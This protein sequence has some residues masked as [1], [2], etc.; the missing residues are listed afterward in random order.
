VATLTVYPGVKPN[1]TRIAVLA[2]DLVTPI[3][4]AGA[5]V[6]YSDYYIALLST[7]QLL[8]YDPVDS[9]GT[10][11]QLLVPPL[12]VTGTP[13]AGQVIEATGPSTAEWSDPETSSLDGPSIE[14]VIASPGSTAGQTK[15]CTKRWN[16]SAHP[17]VGCELIWSTTEATVDGCDV[18]ANFAGL[19]SWRRRHTG[20]HPFAGSTDVRARANGTTN[21]TAAF[22]NWIDRYCRLAEL[23]SGIPN[24][25]PCLRL[26]STDRVLVDDTLVYDPAEHCAD[27]SII[28]A[29]TRSTSDFGAMILWNRN[30]G[31][32]GYDTRPMFSIGQRGMRFQGVWLAPNSGRTLLSAIDWKLMPGGAATAM[33]IHDCNIK[34]FAGG[35]Y[36]TYG[37]TTDIHGSSDGNLEEADFRDVHFGAVEAGIYINKGQPLN[38]TLYKCSFESPSGSVVPNSRGIMV[39]IG[40]C[41][42]SLISPNFG[43]L[44]TGVAIGDNGGGLQL[45]ISGFFDAERTKRLIGRHDGSLDGN[46]GNGGGPITIGP[47]RIAARSYGVASVNPTI[48]AEEDTWIHAPFGNTT[49]TMI[50]TQFLSG[51]EALPRWKIYAP[52]S[53]VVA[54]GVTFPNT[55]PIVTRAAARPQ[56]ISLNN[57]LGRNAEVD[58]GPNVLYDRIHS[59]GGTR[60]P[61]VVSVVIP[62]PVTAVTVPFG[63]VENYPPIVFPPAVVAEAG[64]PSAG[65]LQAPTVSAITTRSCLVTLG[66]APG[67]SASVRVSLS[68]S[69][70]LATGGLLGE[71]AFTGGSTVRATAVS[72]GLR[73]F[74]WLAVWA[75]MNAVPSATEALTSCYNAPNGFI[76]YGSGNGTTGSVYCACYSVAGNTNSPTIAISAADVNRTH[77][78]FF[79]QDATTLRS[80]AKRLQVGSGNAHTP[81]A[82]AAGTRHFIGV[83]NGGTEPTLSD[84]TI[85]GVAG[86]DTG[87]VP[88]LKGVQAYFDSV[89][90]HRRLVHYTRAVPPEVLTEH[91]WQPNGAATI[92]DDGTAPSNITLVS[93]TAPGV[94]FVVPDPSW[95][96]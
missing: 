65:S 1:G 69:P 40:S 22:Q 75:H 23:E 31:Q 13:T 25:G 85:L 24:N 42:M 16:E 10:P 79:T 93:G 55:D 17:G 20:Q 29:P 57:C 76:V 45:S 70:R 58:G 44:S 63:K 77:L 6:G 84:W 83:N 92:V 60:S 30:S 82:A 68:L 62:D 66:A 95:V 33:K 87:A 12:L 54:T 2:Q 78:F 15:V 5:V 81:T 50:G 14:T 26:E 8:D 49:L 52:D 80:Y 56:L 67:A 91:L 38:W 36:M 32:A 3:P 39:D 18:F 64:T 96:T 90:A 88:D 7:G 53:N 51:P 28:G 43:L 4:D 94:A 19:G 86:S 48:A 34:L 47:G 72:G 46:A 37:L 59:P 74:K 71:T 27:L 9:G 35:H 41:S 61:S 89:K 11:I 73:N 21:N